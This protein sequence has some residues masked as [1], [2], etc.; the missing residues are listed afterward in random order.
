MFWF[1]Q[2]NLLVVGNKC[3]KWIRRVAIHF[4][5]PLFRLDKF[6]TVKEKGE[7]GQIEIKTHEYT[8]KEALAIF[9]EFMFFAFFA[10]FFLLNSVLLVIL[11]W[12]VQTPLTI[13]K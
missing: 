4:C 9:N 10:Y 6:K 1:Y 13:E 11:P 8:P 3:P 7:D 2:M 12:L 5:C